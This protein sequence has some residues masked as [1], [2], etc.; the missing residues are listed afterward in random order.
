MTLHF[1]ITT[2]LFHLNRFNCR[3]FKWDL[4]KCR[5]I[6]RDTNHMMR[7]V[8]SV[9]IKFLLLHRNHAIQLQHR[10]LTVASPTS[11]D[12]LHN[13]RGNKN[14]NWASNMQFCWPWSVNIA[15]YQWNK[16]S[17]VTS[18]PYC[19]SLPSHY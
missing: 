13:A 14:V 11:C 3:T 1:A 18:K 6:S 19:I 17:R 2:I 8:L 5:Q 12:V 4:N 16:P 9:H 10:N 15:Q 7:F